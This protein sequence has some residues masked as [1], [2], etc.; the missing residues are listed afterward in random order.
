M[1]RYFKLYYLF[2]FLCF[3]GFSIIETPTLVYPKNN[4]V[5]YDTV[6]LFKWDKQIGN[7]IT[8]RFEIAYDTIFSNIFMQAGN[9]LNNFITAHNLPNNTILYWR[10]KAFDGIIFST[11]SSTRICRLFNPSFLPNLRLWL[12][13]DK[14]VS[15]DIANNI[16]QWDDQSGNNNNA[17]QIISGMRPKYVDSVSNLNNLPTVRFDGIDD[18]LR[19]S[20]NT[21]L[22]FGNKLSLYFATKRNLLSVNQTFISK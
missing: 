4:I 8:Y 14:G 5:L 3:E 6:S 16:F 7:T 13:A 19:I 21:S 15:K 2:I 10:V 11:W 9:L 12:R 22:D 1:F 20:T 17:F 18:F